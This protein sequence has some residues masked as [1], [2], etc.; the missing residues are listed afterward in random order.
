MA[1]HKAPPSLGFS[2]QEHWSELPFP[3]PIH[4]SEKWK[5]SHSVMY[6]SS[7]AH[8]L[9]PTRVLCPWDFPGKSTGV[10]C[11]R[12]L[13]IS[14]WGPSLYNRIIYSYECSGEVLAL[15]KG[16]L[17]LNPGFTTYWGLGSKHNFSDLQFHCPW[18][19]TNDNSCLANFIRLFWGPAEKCM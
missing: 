16:G 9:Q 13:R 7:W 11:H 2:R 12:L 3:S 6:D 4:E 17:V 5:W 15:G 14:G 1:A 19:G 10:E 8:G 18:N